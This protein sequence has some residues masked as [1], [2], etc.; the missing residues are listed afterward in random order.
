MQNL[1][2]STNNKYYELQTKLRLNYNELLKVDSDKMQN[3]EQLQ[4]IVNIKDKC[5]FEESLNIEYNF[6]HNTP[7]KSNKFSIFYLN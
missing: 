5:E 2:N 4:K 7:N 6:P 3:E 1:A